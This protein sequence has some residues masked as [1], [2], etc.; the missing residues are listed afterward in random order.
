MHL[1]LQRGLSAIAEHLIS[2][3]HWPTYRPTRLHCVRMAAGMN[4]VCRRKAPPDADVL[5]LAK[6]V[7][8]HAAGAEFN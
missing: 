3:T 4:Q 8:N 7:Q 1:A 2:L 6:N 5:G